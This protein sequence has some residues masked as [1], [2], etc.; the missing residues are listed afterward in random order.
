M[1]LDIRFLM[2]YAWL[3]YYLHVQH[4]ST[5]DLTPFFFADKILLRLLRLLVTR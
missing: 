2:L 5:A 4:E 1:F 3:T